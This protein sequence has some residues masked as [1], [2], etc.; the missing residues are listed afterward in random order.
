MYKDKQTILVVDD[1]EVNID[2]LLGILDSYDVVAATDGASALEIVETQDIDLILLDIM[3]PEMDGFE[4]CQRIQADEKN[5][6]IPIIFITAILD[7]AVIERAY[8]IGGVDYI[9]KPF[10][11]KELL[12][13]IKREL[14]LRY[15]IK[16]LEY[17]AAHDVMTGIYNRGKFFELAQKLFDEDSNLVAVMIDIDKFK[18]INDTYGHPLGDKVIIAVTQAIAAHLPEGA[19]FGR[20]GGEE[21]AIICSHDSLNKARDTVE[22]MRKQIENTQIITENGTEVT[23]TISAGIAGLDTNTKSLDHLLKKADD[24]LYEAKNSGRNKT[25]FRV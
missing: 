11:P 13:K 18:A 23:C 20:L 16:N 8:D 9:T 17:T 24:M 4:V 15:L 3:M 6:E 2:I 1:T 10:K 19:I 14:K 21:F 25:I 5:R 12:A 7:E 22:S